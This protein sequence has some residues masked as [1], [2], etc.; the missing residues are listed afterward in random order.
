MLRIG[1]ILKQTRTKQGLTLEDMEQRTKI[2]VHQLEALEQE[3]Y[4][5]LPS[6]LWARGLTTTYANHLGLDG[7]AL[8]EEFFPSEPS[9]HA[10]PPSRR[11][12]ELI[13]APL[14]Q[15]WRKL[16]A[17]GL[18]ATILTV[19]VVATAVFFAHEDGFLGS[20]PQRFVI[21]ASTDVGVA[22]ED[23]VITMKVAKD[24]VGIL[25]I[26]GNTLVEVPGHGEKEISAASG[27]GGPELTRRTVTRL[28]GVEVQHYVAI[29]A[30]GTKKIVDQVGGV[31]VDVPNPIVG[32]ASI[33]GPNLTLRPG[34]QV[35]NGDQALVYLQG[36]D[37][38][39]EQERAE[40]QQ[41]FI[42]S[43]LRQA[44]DPGTLLRNPTTIGTLFKHVQT[45]TS[46][47]E[48]IEVA[49]RLRT[50]ESF[51][52]AGEAQILPGRETAVSPQQGD[53]SKDYWMMDAQKLSHTINQT[54]R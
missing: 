28:T 47:I 53:P 9:S 54:L 29:D 27:L 45:N 33:G 40:R 20:D 21:L 5:S 34:S 16:L 30:E 37:L 15:H 4:D 8:A 36:E 13:L 52:A 7:V 1:Q 23:H 38:P 41:V 11:R 44:L 26:P 24:N 18:G 17:A 43:M 39:N 46:P 25:T 51:D 3:E 42:H 10:Q 49:S 31:Q 22:G 48:A 50:L 19:A 32:K 6:I 2:R 35:L 14:R 12:G